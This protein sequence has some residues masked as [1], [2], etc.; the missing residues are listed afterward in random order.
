MISEPLELRPGA[1]VVSLGVDGKPDTLRR[2]TNSMVCFADA[3]GDTLFDVR[4]YHASFIPLIYRARALTASWMVAPLTGC[5]GR[6][7]TWSEHL[8]RSTTN[9]IRT[10]LNRISTSQPAGRPSTLEFGRLRSE[11]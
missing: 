11:T 8:I 1:T 6:L 4:C 5:T 2:G 9:S 10:D 3:P 7:A